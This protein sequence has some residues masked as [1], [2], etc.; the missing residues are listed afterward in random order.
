MRPFE[1]VT[2]PC[3]S[4]PLLSKREATTTAM[5]D[6][7]DYE[8]LAEAELAKASDAA[9]PALRNAHLDQA[10]IFATLAERQRLALGS[11]EGDTRR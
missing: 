1:T 2:V 7:I 3:R 9:D 11:T 4:F 5:Q 10:S 8:T 6:P